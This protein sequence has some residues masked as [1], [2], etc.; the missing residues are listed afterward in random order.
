MKSYSIVIGLSD[1]LTLILEVFGVVLLGVPL[2]VWIR[3]IEAPAHHLTV[4]NS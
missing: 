1:W 3:D 4:S 2:V